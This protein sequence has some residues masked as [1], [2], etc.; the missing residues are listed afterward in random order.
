MHYGNRAARSGLHPHTTPSVFYN[1]MSTN[2][3]LQPSYWKWIL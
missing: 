2:T 1:I 3:I